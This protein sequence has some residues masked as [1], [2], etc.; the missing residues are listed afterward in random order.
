M[1]RELIGSAGHEFVVIEVIGE[2]WQEKLGRNCESGT[3]KNLLLLREESL[4][5]RLKKEKENIEA[6][7]QR[8]L[9][10]G[11]GPA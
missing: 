2:G 4:I 1:V 8:S 3:S 10:V 7:D 5:E 6:A 11:R 9:V